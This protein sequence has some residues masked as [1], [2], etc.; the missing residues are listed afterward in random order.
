MTETK[1]T[2]AAVRNAPPATA[3]EMAGR[4][5]LGVSRIGVNRY[6]QN[7]RGFDPR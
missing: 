2:D 6:D 4:N 7:Q 3:E 5:A 1:R